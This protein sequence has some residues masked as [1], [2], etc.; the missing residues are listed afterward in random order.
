MIFR[1]PTQLKIYIKPG[2]TDMRKSYVSLMT[3]IE[4]EM[5]LDPYSECIFLFCGRS[6]K[7][8]KAIYWDGN[9]FCLWQK[10]LSHGYFPWPSS[11]DK[12]SDLSSQELRW[13]LEG[14]DFRKKHKILTK[15]VA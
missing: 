1:D 9:G 14:I 4:W 7:L 2:S 10:K 11:Q 8:V 6:K 5:K 15:N 12:V 13:M 3:I